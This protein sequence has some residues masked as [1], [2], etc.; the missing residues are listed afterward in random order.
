[1]KKCTV[2]GYQ[3]KDDANIVRCPACNSLLNEAKKEASIKVPQKEI[4]KSSSQSL[5][6][7]YQVFLDSESL[8]RLATAKQSGVGCQKDEE[9]A[10]E[11]YRVLAFRGHFPGMTKLAE[12]LLAKNPPQLEL[13][14]QLL[15]MASDGGYMPAKVCYSTIDFRKLS[16]PLSLDLTNVENNFSKIV[17]AALPYIV[18]IHVYTGINTDHASGMAGS[19]FITID[20]YVVTNAHVTGENPEMI[21]ANFDPSID[22]K[23]HP[24]YPLAIVPELDLAILRFGDDIEEKFIGKTNLPLNTGSVDYG[25]SVYTIGNPLD[26]GISVCKGIVSSPDRKFGY[27]EGVESVI[28]VDFT[29]NHGNS[30]GAC[31]NLKNEV[32]GVVTYCPTDSEGEITMCVPTAYI[33]ALIKIIEEELNKELNKQ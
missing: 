2:C 26:I 3:I 16:E 29:A 27:P 1:M 21:I 12:I 19:G 24:L 28:Q 11:I 17:K 9:E 4:K 25:E 32:V 6:L 8:Y 5:I 31:L 15:K 33:V 13:A 18:T 7:K 10:E 23:E 30:G 14:C 22:K 20:G